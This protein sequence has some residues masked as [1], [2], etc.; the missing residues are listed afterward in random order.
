MKVHGQTNQTLQPKI[1]RLT[2]IYLARTYAKRCTGYSCYTETNATTGNKEKQSMQ[3]HVSLRYNDLVFIALFFRLLR[4]HW[5]ESDLHHVCLFSVYLLYLVSVRWFRPPS[6]EDYIAAEQS[7]PR[8][9]VTSEER[10]LWRTSFVWVWRK[11]RLAAVKIR[12]H[13]RLKSLNLTQNTRFV[14]YLVYR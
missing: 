11:S 10:L 1:N 4:R 14:G 2:L 3:T 8:G 9:S 12:V 6:R 13:V 7:R 5:L